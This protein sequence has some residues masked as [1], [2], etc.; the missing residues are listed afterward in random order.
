MNVIA[1]DRGP[2]IYTVASSRAL[3][4]VLFELGVD[5]PFWHGQAQCK[6]NG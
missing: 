3:G 5:V 1:T 6:S 2:R 4:H